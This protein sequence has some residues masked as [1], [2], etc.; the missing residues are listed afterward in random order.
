MHF[1]LR[2]LDTVVNVPHAVH[3]CELDI[4]YLLLSML[5]LRSSIKNNLEAKLSAPGCNEPSKIEMY[6][7]HLWV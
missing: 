6:V 7:L 4:L 3:V 1:I 2:D 5:H